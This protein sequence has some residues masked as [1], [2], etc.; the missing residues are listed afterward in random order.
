VIAHCLG[1]EELSEELRKHLLIENRVECTAED[2]E[3]G[4]FPKAANLED[5]EEV[6]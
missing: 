3:N 5:I 2:K 6:S 4:D 1:L